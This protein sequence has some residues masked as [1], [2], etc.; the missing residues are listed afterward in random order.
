M[1]KEPS[2]AGLSIE[3]VAAAATAGDPERLAGFPERILDL[4]LDGVMAR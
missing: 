4:V 3:R 1:S 2:A